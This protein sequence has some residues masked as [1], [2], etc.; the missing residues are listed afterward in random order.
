MTLLPGRTLLE[1]L[2]GER[3]ARPRATGDSRTALRDSILRNVQD[4]LSVRLGN[5]A[6]QTDLGMPPPGELLRDHP[7]CVPRVQAIIA[8]CI[9][10]YEPR[11]TAVRVT[12]LPQ[13]DTLAIRFQI[14]A[15]YADASRA[16]VSF[17]TSVDQD[18][19]IACTV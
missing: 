11:L 19:Q 12:H 7:A 6:A 13:D 14:V 3:G 8:A 16:P 5:A 9:A 1:R 18:G 4:L 15:Q 17:S 2:A 10:R